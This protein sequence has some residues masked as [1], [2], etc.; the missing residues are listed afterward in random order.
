M[1][2]FRPYDD[3]YKLYDENGAFIENKN[4]ISKENKI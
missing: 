3:N 4:V 2:N 1:K